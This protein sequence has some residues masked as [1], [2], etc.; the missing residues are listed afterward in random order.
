[1]DELT[2]REPDPKE[3]LLAKETAGMLEAAVT[4]MPATFC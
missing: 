4:A 1:M 3:A 2:S